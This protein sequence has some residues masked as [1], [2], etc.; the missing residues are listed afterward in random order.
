M[1]HWFP[2]HIPQ[3]NKRRVNGKRKGKERSGFRFHFRIC[4][5][6]VLGNNHGNNNNMQFYV[7][8]TLTHT[9]LPIPSKHILTYNA[10]YNS[11]SC[12]VK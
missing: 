1:W 7:A 4:G 9:Y 3:D 12:E 2:V 5:M 6:A 10:G 8:P 11:M